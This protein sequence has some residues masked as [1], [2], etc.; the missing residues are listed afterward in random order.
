MIQET[1]NLTDKKSDVSF[2]GFSLHECL[3]ETD[4]DSAKYIRAVYRTAL[5]LANQ[6]QFGFEVGGFWLMLEQIDQL[7]ALPDFYPPH[8]APRVARA[9]EAFLRAQI[10]ENVAS[11]GSV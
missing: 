7:R 2:I 3:I 1:A 9:V 11:M 10:H 4:C 8:E 5:E 6:N